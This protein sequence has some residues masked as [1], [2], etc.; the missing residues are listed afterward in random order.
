MKF[1]D[2]LFEKELKEY[3]Y[4]FEQYKKLENFKQAF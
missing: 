1:S 4:P 2:T 3:L